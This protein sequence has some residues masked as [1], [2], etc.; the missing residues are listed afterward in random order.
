M[1]DTFPLYA[2]NLKKRIFI[3]AAVGNILDTYDLILI[4]LMATTLSKVFFPPSSDPYAHLIDILYV[5]FIGLLMRPIGNIVMALFADQIGR[6]KLMFVSITF[7]GICS[8]FIGLLPSY[9]S[10]GV[11]STIL[12]I[13]IR[14][15]MNLFVGVCLFLYPHLAFLVFIQL[16]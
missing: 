6:K 11:W 4:S 9:Q 5:F 8:S 15:F 14:I 1:I 2:L 7:T 10:I 13:S 3:S 12:F 16:F